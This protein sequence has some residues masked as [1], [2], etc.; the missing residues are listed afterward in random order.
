MFSQDGLNKNV[1]YWK[2]CYYTFSSTANIGQRACFIEVVG[3]G[4]EWIKTNN[5]TCIDREDDCKAKQ[6]QSLEGEMYAPLV[7]SVLSREAKGRPDGGCSAEFCSLWQP[8]GPREWHGTACDGEGEVEYPFP[9]GNI[10]VLYFQVKAEHIPS[11]AIRPLEVMSDSCI[12]ILVMAGL[13]WGHR[14]VPAFLS[15]FVHLRELKVRL[16]WLVVQ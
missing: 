3:D 13:L 16:W 6:L 5:L 11:R 15:S 14:L 2:Y 12:S 1:E 7:G 8:Q 4:D 10:L 9:T